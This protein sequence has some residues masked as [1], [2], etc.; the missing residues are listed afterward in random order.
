MSQ[1]NDRV[2]EWLANRTAG[3]IIRDGH[4]LEAL[5]AADKQWSELEELKIMK[6]M[7]DAGEHGMRPA[8]PEEVEFVADI[9]QRTD[10]S[11]PAGTN[12]TDS[13]AYMKLR[14]SNEE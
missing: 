7:L 9:L 8:T 10:D 6:T 3:E 14:N 1:S 4:T 5:E 12:L 13:A 2:A 11:R